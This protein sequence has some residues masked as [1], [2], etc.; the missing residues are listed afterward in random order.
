MY[1]S[2]HRISRKCPE[3]GRQNTPKR[4]T[5]RILLILFSLISKELNYTIHFFGTN[6][7]F[8]KLQIAIQ[9]LRTHKSERR[10]SGGSGGQ[11]HIRPN[12]THTGTFEKTDTADGA[13]TGIKSG[14]GTCTETPE[15]SPAI[16][17]TAM[18]SLQHS[19]SP[20]QQPQQ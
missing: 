11:E 8:P 17:R 12:S 14:A 7:R 20:S 4:R 3:F 9:T 6:D 5:I 13:I 15:P 10:S 16:S 18:I 19:S 1:P 2:V